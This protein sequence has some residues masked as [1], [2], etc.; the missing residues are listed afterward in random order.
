MLSTAFPDLAHSQPGEIQAEA[1]PA[2]L[3]LVVVNNPGVDE[4]EDMAVKEVKSVI[5]WREFVTWNGGGVEDRKI[6]AL[7][8]TLHRDEVAN[9]QFTRCA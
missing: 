2:L 9:L 8:A 5:D 1:L 3:N 6:S 4:P 7:A